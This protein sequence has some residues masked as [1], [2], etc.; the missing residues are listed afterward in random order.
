VVDHLVP[1]TLQRLG[2]VGLELEA[3]V[4]GAEVHAHAAQ[5]GR[6]RP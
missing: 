2:Q 4:V 6:T 5:S 1:E 3:G